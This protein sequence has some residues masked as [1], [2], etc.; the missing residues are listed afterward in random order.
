MSSSAPQ[1][2]VK[3]WPSLSSAPLP[4]RMT[5]QTRSDPQPRMNQSELGHSRK[6]W[7]P[8]MNG[9][10]VIIGAMGQPCWALQARTTEARRQTEKN[11]Q[12]RRILRGAQERE[13]PGV[14]ALQTPILDPTS[15]PAQVS[16]RF[17]LSACLFAHLLGFYYSI[18]KNFHKCS[19]SV[20]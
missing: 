4:T 8:G 12:N 14:P 3:G 2:W 15:L 20:G 7:A 18:Q 17:Q 1:G 19:E 13:L 9:G 11:N 16:E 5:H 6:V 10:H